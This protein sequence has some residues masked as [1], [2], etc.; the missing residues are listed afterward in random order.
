M[1]PNRVEYEGSLYNRGGGAINTSIDAKGEIVDVCHGFERKC[2]IPSK[3]NLDDGIACGEEM[4]ERFT[5]EVARNASHIDGSLLKRSSTTPL[6]IHL[7]S[8]LN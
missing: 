7:L 6:L 2:G 8:I 1:N 5:V 3:P 4:A